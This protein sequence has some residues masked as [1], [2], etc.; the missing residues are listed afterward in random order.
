[1]KSI[2]L[3]LTDIVKGMRRRL[4]YG[5]LT[6]LCESIK[7]HGILQPI[8]VCGTSLPY[9]LYAGGRRLKACQEIGLATIPVRIFENEPTELQLREVELEE[10][11]QR[12][13]LTWQERA[14]LIEEIHNLKT[15]LHGPKLSTSPNAPGHSQRDTAKL[16]GANPGS[17]TQEIRLAQALKQFPNLDWSACK[18]RNEGLKMLHGMA[19]TLDHNVRASE[20]SA[21]L[22]STNLQKPGEEASL[23]AAKRARKFLADAYVIKDCLVA[24]EELQ[25]GLFNLAEVDPPYAIDL[26]K[27]KKGSSSSIDAYNEV[28][29]TEY[30]EFL[31]KLLRRLYRVMAPD[32]YVLFWFSM[33]PWFET[34]YQA[35]IR[36]GFN[37]S[38]NCAIWVKDYGSTNSPN[39]TLA[40][41]YDS[42]FYASKGHPKLNRPG[43]DN[44]FIHKPVPNQY[45]YHPTERPEAL[46]IDMLTTFTGPGSRI[47]VPFAGSG[48]TFKAAMRA[49]MTSIGYDLSQDYRNGY[50]ASL[51]DF[52]L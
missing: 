44:A 22:N 32:S 33:E 14:L 40:S 31:D 23:S 20:F 49:S 16:I 2:E 27:S 41:V 38:R 37:T 26:V 29:V 18:T 13:D 30:P 5:D 43:H 3:P 42:F 50:L 4:D 46:L 28:M 1:M 9:T 24:L 17:V 47:L 35:L 7:K 51:E 10:N 12:K 6:E 36:A 15:T 21:T 8:I 52:V 19:K 11:I 25:P 34:V 45:K 48:V 39:T